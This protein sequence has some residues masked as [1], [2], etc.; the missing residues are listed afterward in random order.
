MSGEE[1]QHKCGNARDCSSNSLQ[2][3]ADTLD[4]VYISCGIKWVHN[5]RFS[6]KGNSTRI[7]NFQQRI[8]FIFSGLN[9]ANGNCILGTKLL[10]KDFIEVGVIRLNGNRCVGVS[11]SLSDNLKTGIQC[12]FDIISQLQD[13]VNSKVQKSYIGGS[14]QGAICRFTRNANAAFL[15]EGGI[16]GNDVVLIIDNSFYAGISNANKRDRGI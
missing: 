13:A 7:R 2:I 12:V 8:G 4:L 1:H 16:S 9:N 10:Q 3:E 6:C 5:A 15:Q 14:A 11:Q